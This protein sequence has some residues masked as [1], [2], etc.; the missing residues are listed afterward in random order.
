MCLKFS[1]VLGDCCEHEPLKRMF[2]RPLAE[3]V[4][5]SQRLRLVILIGR[6]LPYALA[7]PKMAVLLGLPHSA[8]V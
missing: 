7:E 6:K 1:S 5:E 4:R 3:T 8:R 2:G